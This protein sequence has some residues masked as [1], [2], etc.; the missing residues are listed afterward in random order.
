MVLIALCGHNSFYTMAHSEEQAQ[1]EPKLKRKHQTKAMNKKSRK[2]LQGSIRVINT[3]L[4]R[5][6]VTTLKEQCCDCSRAT[7]TNELCYTVFSP[8]E[9][10]QYYQKLP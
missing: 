5:G 6:A 3:V 2:S 8:I 4:V 7:F 9:T 10:H 1:E